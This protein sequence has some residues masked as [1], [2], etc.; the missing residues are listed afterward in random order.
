MYV[1]T[2]FA[3]AL[4]MTIVSTICWGSFANTLKLT[5]NYRFELY[6]WDY[7]FGIVLTSLVLGHTMGAMRDNLHATTW[8]NFGYAALGGSPLNTRNFL[9]IAAI[10]I[11]G[12]A[13]AF[14]KRVAI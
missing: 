8:T 9:L 10:V 2:T 14:P 6:Y 11:G 7:A 5:K 1:P 4:V 13:I 3:A 12:L